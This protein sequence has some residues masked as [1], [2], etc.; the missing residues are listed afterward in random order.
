MRTNS[1]KL[2]DKVEVVTGAFKGIGAAIAK[3]PIRQ[4]KLPS[5][6]K[7]KTTF[8]RKHEWN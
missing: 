8:Q 2:N 4:R 6:T 1:N 3:Q 7:Q 5:F